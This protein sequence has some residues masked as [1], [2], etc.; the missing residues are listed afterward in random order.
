MVETEAL[1]GPL[2]GSQSQMISVYKKKGHIALMITI[3]ALQKWTE[4]V[5]LSAVKEALEIPNTFT[6]LRSEHTYK[7]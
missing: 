1:M 5:W 2:P 4:I 6:S 3:H 7:F